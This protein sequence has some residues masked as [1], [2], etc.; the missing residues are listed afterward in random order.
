MVR[1]GRDTALSMK[2]YVAFRLLAVMG[3]LGDALGVN[4]L[5][6]P[7][8]SHID[9]VPAELRPF[10]PEHFDVDAFKAFRPP[11]SICGGFWAQNIA[12]GLAVFSELPDDRLL[13]LRYEDF[14][15]DPNRQLDRLAVFLG[16]KF[17]DEDWSARCAA[18]VRPPRWTWRDLPDDEASA[19]TEACR[20]GFDL[21][22]TQGVEYEV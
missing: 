2:A 12:S 8:R 17:I 9:R 1:D 10:L 13:T 11:L 7:D 5:T 19:L 4:P 16:P 14:F 15:T 18:T 21:L 22:A 3:S 20:P 6:S